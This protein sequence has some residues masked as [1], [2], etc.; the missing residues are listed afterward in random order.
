MPP[1]NYFKVKPAEKAPF[2]YPKIQIKI[3]RDKQTL[4]QKFKQP[5]L[6][7]IGI[8]VRVGRRIRLEKEIEVKEARVSV[9][10]EKRDKR[11]RKT[12][13]MEEMIFD[14]DDELVKK[15]K[16]YLDVPHLEIKPHYFNNRY[17]FF[18]DIQAQ[19][20]DCLLYTSPSPRDS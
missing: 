19:I 3:E 9:D 2:R 16:H 7:R 12:K 1:S 13:R 18:K 6:I 20:G 4:Y 17:G 8:P 11:E 5:V 15:Y 10:G 14:T